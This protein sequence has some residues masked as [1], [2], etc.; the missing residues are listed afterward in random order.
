[1]QSF[2]KDRLKKAEQ[3]LLKNK[4]VLRDTRNFTFADKNKVNI[5]AW[6][7]TDREVQNIGDFLSVIIVKKAA[8]LHGIDAE[9]FVNGT[10]HLY[11]VGSVLMG[12]Q[13]A[14]VWGAGF[15]YDFSDNRF[16]PLY[17]AIHKFWHKTDIRAVRGPETRR[18]LLKM[19]IN[20]P[21]VYGDPAVLLPLF[22]KPKL[23]EKKKYVIIPHYSRYNEYSKYNNVM[24]TF[25]KN[26]REFINNLCS[27]DL[28]ISSSLHGIILSEAY[29]IPCVMLD[30]TPSTDITK[31]KD[32]YYS[33][34]R[35]DFTIAKS[36]E[37]AIETKV[38]LP[39]AE[40]ISK[41]QNNLLETFPADLWDN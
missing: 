40:V 6:I 37:E 14:T 26:W 15:G 20:C 27:A 5:N 12:Y 31:Y 21:E 32:W 28:V 34:G 35:Y 24:S 22:Y 30:T 10:K 39:S 18:I 3:I 19:G 4:I 1:M 38:S 29:G 25:T 16:F 13:D 11:A 36:V 17:S 33:T 2:Q 7:D 23:L 9:K 8:E 41:M